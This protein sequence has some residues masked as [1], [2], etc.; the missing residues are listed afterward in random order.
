MRRLIRPLLDR[1]GLSAS[2]LG[3]LLAVGLAGDVLEAAFPATLLL[4]AIAGVSLL[5]GLALARLRPDAGWPHG[6]LTFAALLL[7][8]FGLLATAQRAIGSQRGL[9][10]AASSRIA[11]WQDGLFSGPVREAA[12]ADVLRVALDDPAA[13]LLQRPVS[14]DEFLFTFW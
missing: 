11:A 8:G 7:L 3:A 1:P 9:L 12:A 4:V 6:V 13:P 5:G 2:A 10:G 14:A